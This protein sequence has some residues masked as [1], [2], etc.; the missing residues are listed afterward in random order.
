M[1]D[2]AFLTFDELLDRS[3][4]DPNAEA[5]LERRYRQTAAILVVDYTSMVHRT[6]HHGIVYALSLARRAERVMHPAVEAHDGEVVKRVADSWFAVF[7]DPAR[8]LG[9]LLDGMAALREFNAPRTGSIDD[10]SRNEPI[11]ACAGLAFGA[12]L[13]LP[14]TDLYG[15]EVNRAFVLG[16]DTARASETLVTDA[17]LG[18]LGPPPQGVG[19]HRAPGDRVAEVGFPFHIVADYR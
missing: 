8:A 1:T 2:P 12:S 6:D 5:E 3:L 11:Y 10:G 16:E 7:P 15:E 18:A 17:F 14:G 4:D 9:A 19:V 13:V